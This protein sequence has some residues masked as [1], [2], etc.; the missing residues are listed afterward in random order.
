MSDKDVMRLAG[1]ADCDPRTVVSIYDGAPS[2]KRTRGRIEAAARK[3][4]LPLPPKAQTQGK[5]NNKTK[6]QEKRA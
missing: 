3:L 2:R 6:N 4:R 5:A 1:E